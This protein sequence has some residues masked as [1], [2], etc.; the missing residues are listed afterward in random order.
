MLELTD[1]CRRRRSLLCLGLDPDP[2]RLPE[3]FQGEEDPVLA[4]NRELIDAT[5]DVVA[6]YKPNFAFY[7]ALG[8]RGFLTLAS[9]IEHVGNRAFVIGDAK[10]GD[11]GNTS[12]R[13]AELAF[14]HLGC[15]ALTLAPYMGEDSLRPFLDWRDEHHATFSGRDFQ[16]GTGAYVLALTSNP[17]AAD[18][19]L[20]DS[21]GRP[22]YQRVLERVAEWNRSWGGGRLGVV[23]GAT[24]P[25]QLAEIRREFPE[26]HLLIPGVGAQGGELEAVLEAVLPLGRSGALVNVSRG[27]LYGD[28]PRASVREA[29]ERASALNDTIN[30][31]T[32]WWL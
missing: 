13:Y 14:G 10:R 17:G 31:F 15:H 11:I 4:Y 12:Q 16:P 24:R 18:F 6:A 7:E 28:K 22:L 2:E 29:R 32:E 1:H 21:G 27:I 8:P 26:L 25:A 5:A 30:A 19:Q 20:R 3:R 23:A 9:T